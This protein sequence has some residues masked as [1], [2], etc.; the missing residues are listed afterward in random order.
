VPHHNWADVTNTNGYN[1]YWPNPG[2][3]TNGIG[4]PVARVAKNL[5][6]PI[7]V[8]NIYRDYA[9]GPASIWQGIY[10][11]GVET[12]G[13][14]LFP[15]SGG[16]FDFFIRGSAGTLQFGRCEPCG[17]SVLSENDAFAWGGTLAGGLDWA[18]VSL[19][20]SIDHY[21][22][23]DTFHFSNWSTVDDG[24]S[25]ITSIWR[26]VSVDGG[27]YGQ[28]TNAWASDFV[29][30]PGHTYKFAFFAR[31]AVGDSEYSYTN[32][33]TVDYSGGRKMTSSAASVPLTISK[34]YTG[35]QWKDLT[36]RK[37]HNGAAFVEISN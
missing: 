23:D 28:V 19:P 1:G 12:Q 4:M 16:T 9:A 7:Y 30:A 17:N 5:S 2:V 27:L 25:A 21:Q 37:R 6:Q 34:R 22:D 32:T 31:N 10:Y 14:F 26:E 13:G 36:T 29:G 3:K 11:Q 20:V 33:F 8:G 18:Q 15:S 24:G 35:S